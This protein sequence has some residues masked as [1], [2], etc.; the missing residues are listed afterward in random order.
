MAVP[1]TLTGDKFMSVFSNL[2]KSEP[3]EEPEYTTYDIIPIIGKEEGKMMKAVKKAGIPDELNSVF[4]DAIEDG[5]DSCHEVS[6][7]ED[8]RAKLVDSRMWMLRETW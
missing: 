4:R 2:F 5:V 7:T 8:Q 1:L 3:V 6:L